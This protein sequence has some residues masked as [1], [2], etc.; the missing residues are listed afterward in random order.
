MCVWLSVIR[1]GSPG[2]APHLPHTC[3]GIGTGK[4]K[5][6][7]GEG[8]GKQE[9]RREGGSKRKIDEDKGKKVEGKK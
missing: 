2:L 8:R 4:R 1:F 9:K 7:G 6:K 3:L 5:E